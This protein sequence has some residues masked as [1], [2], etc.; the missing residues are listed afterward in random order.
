MSSPP[1]LHPATRWVLARA[2]LSPDLPVGLPD[3]PSDVWSEAQRLRMAPRIASRCGRDF[4]VH[5]LGPDIAER[6]LASS[7]HAALQ[8]VKTEALVRHLSAVA[9]EEGL[10]FVVLKGGAL[11]LRRIVALGA[12]P[13][14]DLDI[15][16]S[17]SSA[18][19]LYQVLRHQGW[20]RTTSRRT[21][22]HLPP[23]RHPAWPLLEIHDYLPWVALDGRRWSTFEQLEAAHKLEPLPAPFDNVLTAEGSVLA[24][25]AA[26]A[27]AR[28]S[29]FSLADLVEL[30]HPTEASTAQVLPVAAWLHPTMGESQ[31]AA[32]WALL[33]G[34]RAP[35]NGRASTGWVDE[36]WLRALAASEGMPVGEPRTL[37]RPLPGS[38]RPWLGVA[39][40]VMSRLFATR[41]ELAMHFGPPRAPW[42]YAAFQVRR[43]FEILVRR[44]GLARR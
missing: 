3:N 36:V 22:Y 9:R 32:L 13:L 42:Q 17:R 31:L 40:R 18:C 14:G 37:L 38:P 6:F 26:V 2:F 16:L 21:D 15:L 41:D 11:H 43:W 28:F 25:H 23:L 33:E 20:L 4:L 1:P 27:A 30:C 34:W 10:R 19:R 24:S 35:D 5:D 39:Q 29:V 44:L 7:R 12:R 8:A